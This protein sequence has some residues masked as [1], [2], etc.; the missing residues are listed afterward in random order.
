M[1]PRKSVAVYC[2]NH[3]EYINKLCEHNAEFCYVK[4]GRL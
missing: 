4:I 1:L 2:E 3:K